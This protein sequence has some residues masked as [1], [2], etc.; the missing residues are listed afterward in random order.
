MKVYFLSSVP[1]RLTLS[2]LFYGIV[3]HF[4]RF[5]DLSLSDRV[6]VEFTPQNAHSLSFFLC[7]EILSTPPVGLEVYHLPDGVA[8]YAKEFAPVDITLRLIAQERFGSALVSLFSQGPIQ[9][10][11]Q[12]EEG[13]FLSTLPPS[14]AQATLSSHAGLYFVEGQNHLAIYNKWGNRVFFEEILSFSAEN[15]TLNAYLPLSDSLN[16]QAHCVYSLNEKGCTRTQFKLLQTR[17][18]SGENDLKKIADE[19]LPYAFLEC[20]RLG[21]D[22]SSLLS[23]KLQPSA[24]RLR[25]FLGEFLAVTLTKDPN[26]YGLVYAKGKG[27]F[28]VIPCALTVE[29]GK[30]TDVKC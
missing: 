13:F 8:L 4:E 3:D 23:E 5:A 12:T 21:E 18:R 26:V 28:E 15:N 30:I 2:G 6:F 10:S 1:C 19:L 9:L 27:V 11:L 29:K 7:E 17:T 24:D 20:V 22:Y 16:R 25:E 14:F